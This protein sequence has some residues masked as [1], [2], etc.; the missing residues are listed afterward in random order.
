MFRSLCSPVQK[1]VPILNTENLTAF[2]DNHAGEKHNMK[3]LSQ[4]LAVNVSAGAISHHRMHG[5]L[6][7]LAVSIALV[8][9]I[10][11]LS[12]APEERQATNV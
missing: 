7:P 12:S 2:W 1:V 6:N 5:V 4:R 9:Y 11:L 10:L 3:Q 8:Q